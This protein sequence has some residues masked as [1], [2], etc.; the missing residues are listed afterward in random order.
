MMMSHFTALVKG[1]R[2]NEKVRPRYIRALPVLT[3]Q[4]PVGLTTYSQTSTKLSDIL[5]GCR[6]TARGAASLPYCDALDHPRPARQRL[7]CP[8]TRVTSPGSHFP[9]IGRAPSRGWW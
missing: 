6:V 1:G 3:S 4:S 2:L 7:R 8:S 5:T 9:Q